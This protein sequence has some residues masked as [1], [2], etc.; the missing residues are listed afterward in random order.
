MQRRSFLAKA[1]A[2]A[3]GAAGAS[4]AAPALAQ[5][6]P[7][8]RWR[9]ASSFPKS[10]DT[11]FGGG[12]VLAKSVSAI[13]GGKFQIS[14][15]AGGEIVPGLQVLDA[16]QA[17]TV[18]CGHTALY[19]FFGKDPTWAL[20]AAVPFGLNT[21]QHNAWWYHG[22]G[23][24]LFNEFSKK[25]GVTSLMLGNTNGQMGG[26][27]RKEITSLEDLKGL[28]FR[29]AGLGGQVF[30]KLGVV[31]QQI[32]GGDLYPALEKGTIDAA[33]WVGPYDDEKLG[34]QKV[35]KFYYYPGF[36]EGCT[37]AHLIVNNAAY[38]ALPAE[39]KAALTAASAE[40]TLDMISKYDARN[41][42]AIK[43]LVSTGTQLR[44]FPR[45]VLEAAYRETQ[46][47]YASLTS[48]NADF[49]KVYDSY[50]GSQADQIAWGRINEGTFDSFMA[51]QQQAAAR[52]A[53]K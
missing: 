28:K 22:G 12:E 19:Y 31:T 4:L 37:A 43:R 14:V 49:K 35:A 25:H 18:E 15:H 11:I 46:G 17:N 42:I 36:F 47:I 51:A 45:P 38:E 27:F 8:V 34:L 41:A 23:E 29:I 2:G 33:E 10:L 30:A 20:A 21:R 7:N 24:G 13:T 5:S 39:Y 26:W 44:V 52:P 50:F 53:A 48:A 1:T 6:L 3:A 16:V 40:A 32:A 9:L